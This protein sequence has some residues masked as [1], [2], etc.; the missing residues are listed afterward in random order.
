MPVKTKANPTPAKGFVELPSKPSALIRVAIGDMKK[1]LRANKHARLHRKHEP[2][3]I[4][5]QVW[6]LGTGRD[7]KTCTVCF[8]GS[9]MAGTLGVSDVVVASPQ[10]FDGQT[11]VKLEALNTFRVGNVL[12]GLEWMGVRPA[13]QIAIKVARRVLDRPRGGTNRDACESF[14][15]LFAPFDPADGKNPFTKPTNVR[16][17]LGL[18]SKVA[19]ALELEGY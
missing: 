7:R 9:V 5:M 6:H 14:Q 12:S 10:E 3:E 8:A 11:G 19:R 15:R 16:K 2:Y 18:M 17:F 13:N 4:D 1:V